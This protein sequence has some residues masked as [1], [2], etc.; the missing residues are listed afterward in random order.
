MCTVALRIGLVVGYRRHP[1]TG[2]SW[3]TSSSEAALPRL[4]SRMEHLGV[5]KSA[6]RI[7]MPTGYSSNLA[8][9]AIYLAMASLFVANAV[10]KP[11]EIGA[12][13]SPL[14]LMIVASKGDASVAG[15]GL[16]DPGRWAS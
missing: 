15:A 14:S 11:L 1:G 10:G 8:G 16:A 2:L 13:I 12:Q 3:A 9:T 4:S 7:T 5:S 6:V